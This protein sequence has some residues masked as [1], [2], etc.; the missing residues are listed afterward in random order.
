LKQAKK[1]AREIVENS[2]SEAELIIRDA[3]L[4]AKTMIKEAKEEAI[5]F[6]S[7]SFDPKDRNKGD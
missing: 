1:T 6:R 7:R 3:K 4:E 5:F 2:E